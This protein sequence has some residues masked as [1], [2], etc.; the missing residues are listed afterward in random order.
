MGSRRGD[1]LRV[2]LP[3]RGI[4]LGMG[5]LGTGPCCGWILCRMGVPAAQGWLIRWLGGHGGKRLGAVLP[6]TRRC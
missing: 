6:G 4:F 1:R 5:R 2:G 3:R